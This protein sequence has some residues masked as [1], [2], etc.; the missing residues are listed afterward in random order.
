M[1]YAICC[2]NNNLCIAINGWG[3]NRESSGGIALAGYGSI[4]TSVAYNT[5]FGIVVAIRKCIIDS[6]AFALVKCQ[7]TAIGGKCNG[8]WALAR[9][10]YKCAIG[11][12]EIY[13]FIILRHV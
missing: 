11:K 10:R 6:N 8:E 1:T 13:I 4:P 5:H 12:G 3:S 7:S 9:Y 2:K